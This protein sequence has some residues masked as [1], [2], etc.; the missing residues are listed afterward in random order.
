M[1]FN[2]L[3]KHFGYILN[4]YICFRSELKEKFRKFKKIMCKNV[5]IVYSSSYQRFIDLSHF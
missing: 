5:K 4:N 2:T 3:D 1:E